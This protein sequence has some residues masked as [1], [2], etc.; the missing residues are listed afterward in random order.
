[1]A[2]ILNSPKGAWFCRTVIRVWTW[3]PSLAPPVGLN[4]VQT[5][6]SSSSGS[7][8]NTA[9]MCRAWKQMKKQSYSHVILFKTNVENLLNMFD[10]VCFKT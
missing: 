9:E 4:R 7:V 10:N 2:A 5:K 6:C 1:M 3:A 8:S